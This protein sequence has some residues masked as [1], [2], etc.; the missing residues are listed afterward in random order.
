MVPG[1]VYIYI[2]TIHVRIIKSKKET[3]QFSCFHLFISCGLLTSW[4]C[5]VSGI[6]VIR[7]VQVMM[8]SDH[9]RTNWAP[10]RVF[11]CRQIE[12][13]NSEKSRKLWRNYETNTLPCWVRIHFPTTHELA[14]WPPVAAQRCMVVVLKRVSVDR[15]SHSWKHV[16][17][18]LRP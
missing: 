4:A 17:R 9:S 15:P 12:N 10:R 16:A 3:F 5:E 13:G 7:S 14:E 6:V 8:S 11:F 2:Y 1:Y 18:K